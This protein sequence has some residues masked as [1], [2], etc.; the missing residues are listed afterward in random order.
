M[1]AIDE[2]MKAKDY[3]KLVKK[4]IVTKTGITKTVYVKPD[5]LL[6]SKKTS[7]ISELKVDE[8]DALHKCT[9]V[10]RMSREGFWED[11]ADIRER[12]RW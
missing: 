10:Q 4:Q 6:I 1:T 3:N 8:S 11:R 2:L 9:K 7:A 5:E 12:N